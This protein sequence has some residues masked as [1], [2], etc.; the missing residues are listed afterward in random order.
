M[1]LHKLTYDYLFISSRHF[2]EVQLSLTNLRIYNLREII[3]KALYVH[4]L[5]DSEELGKSQGR[6]NRE[7]ERRKL[8]KAK[9]AASLLQSL[10][11]RTNS[12][13]C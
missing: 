11:L 4:L 6:R 8:S 7:M 2:C 5:Q 12:S 10:I 13:P 1:D 9:H 3:I